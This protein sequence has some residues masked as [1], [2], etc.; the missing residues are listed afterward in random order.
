MNGAMVAMEDAGYIIGSYAVTFAV[1]A[2][3][4]WRVLRGGRRLAEQVDDNDK[5]W[6]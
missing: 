2:G 6:T 5:Y 1:V 4:T 3:F